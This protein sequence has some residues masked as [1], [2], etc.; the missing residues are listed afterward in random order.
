MR[1]TGGREPRLPLPARSATFAPPGIPCRGAHRTRPWCSSTPTPAS[2]ASRR[3]ATGSP[4]VSSSSGSSS[5]STRCGRRSCARSARPSTSTAA[6]RGRWRSR[7]GTS[8]ARRSS[9]RSGSCSAVAT[10]GCSPT[11]PPASPSRRPS[12]PSDASRS[13]S[14]ACGR[15]SS[16]STAT[17]GAPASPSSSDVREA[18]DGRLE[19]MVDANQGW[20]MPGDRAP[21]WDVATAIQCARALEELGVYW[22]EEPL[23]TDD[24]EG[25]A[26][27]RAASGIR[28]AAGELVRDAAARTRPRRPWPRRRRAVRRALRRRARR[29]SSDRGALRS[30]RPRLVAAHLVERAR[31]RREPPRRARL[32][33]RPV[34]GGPVRPARV[35][36]RSAATG[37]LPEVLEIASDGTIVP[38]AGPGLGVELDLAALERWRVA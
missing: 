36:T 1:I 16:V 37:S 13:P 6:D 17:T 29:L 28:I 32:L 11:R 5:G 7:C 9:S 20:R 25:Y 23:R 38:P 30:P 22:L 34:G 15:S 4:I 35:V 14:V 27:L 3:V 12:G 31:P 8:S 33:H 2:R 10:S 18:V 24:H 19:I 26:A 21:R